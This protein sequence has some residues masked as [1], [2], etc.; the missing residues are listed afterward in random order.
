GPAVSRCVTGETQVIGSDLKLQTHTCASTSISLHL[1][2]EPQVGTCV[3]QFQARVTP[4][5]TYLLPMNYVG[6]ALHGL[7]PVFRRWF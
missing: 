5:L 6:L 3:S 2:D 7:P 4:I 1:T